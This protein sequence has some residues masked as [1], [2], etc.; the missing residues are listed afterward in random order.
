MYTAHRCL[1]E[2]KKKK[3][4]VFFLSFGTPLDYSKKKK[5]K[6]KRKVVNT[7][8]LMV[9]ITTQKKN[10]SGKLFNQETSLLHRL[11]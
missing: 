10:Y 2:A 1:V 4:L 7:M 8:L 6:R 3:E 9:I 5:K 11:L